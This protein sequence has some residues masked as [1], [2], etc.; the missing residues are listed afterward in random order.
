MNNS[1]QVLK[2]VFLK[3]R[4]AHASIP[5]LLRDD[6][7]SIFKE[8]SWLIIFPQVYSVSTGSVFFTYVG[9]FSFKISAFQF[10]FL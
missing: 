9:A 1:W 5:I 10:Y 3:M 4:S 6:C 2:A 7:L 8:M